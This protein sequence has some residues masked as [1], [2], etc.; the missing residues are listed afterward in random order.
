VEALVTKFKPGVVR[1][2]NLVDPTNLESAFSH[3]DFVIGRH[4]DK[5]VINPILNILN[6]NTVKP[7]IPSYYS[8]NA[9]TLN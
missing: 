8:A 7:I 6:S 1:E 5:L 2:V 3:I 9:R 4:I